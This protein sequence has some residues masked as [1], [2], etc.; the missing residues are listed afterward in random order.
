M[1]KI[2]AFLLA[3]AMMFSLVACGGGAEETPAPEEEKAPVEEQAPDTVEHSDELTVY[4]AFPEAEV[5]YYYNAFEKATGIKINS[6][7]LSAGQP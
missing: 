2:W 4:T 7:R 1:K 5:I 3:S 6:I